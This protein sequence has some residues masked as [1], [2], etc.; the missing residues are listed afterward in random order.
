MQ[1]RQGARNFVRIGMG[2]KTLVLGFRLPFRKLELR[3]QISVIIRNQ[4]VTVNNNGPF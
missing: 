2:I 1:R 4:D 3:E